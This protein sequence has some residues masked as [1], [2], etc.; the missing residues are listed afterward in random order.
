MTDG[1]H[2]DFETRSSVNLPKF[3]AYVYATDP[4]TEVLCMAYKWGC[5]PAQLWTPDKPFPEKVAKHIANGG[6]IIAH[7]AQFERLIFWYI[8]CPDFGV[9][10][11]E[12]EQFYCT[13]NLARSRGLP[14]KLELASAL[15]GGTGKDPRGDEL[16]RECCIPPYNDELLPELYEYC[17]T[18]V[19]AEAA[20][21][22]CLPALT[23][24]EQHDY[25]V[26]ERI[27]DRGV[28]VDV[29]F[30][31]AATEYKED[32][33][34]DLSVVLERVT[35]GEITKPTQSQRI[36]AWLAERCPRDCLRSTKTKSGWTSNRQALEMLLNEEDDVPAD[37]REVAQARLDGANVSVTKYQTMARIA[38]QDEEHRIRGAFILNAAITG[39]FSSRQA[40]LHNFPRSVPE[41]A[42]E[43]MD[44][45][46]E[47]Y[48]IETP[49]R[50]L[51]GLLRPTLI[52]AEGN[53]F[54]GG[55][56]SAIEA[57]LT[58]WA[59]RGWGGDVVVKRFADGVDVYIEQALDMGLTEEERQLG[60]VAILACGFGG[61]G[62]A[63]LS[64]GRN[65][66]LRLEFNEAQAYALAWRD[67]NRWAPALWAALERA[68][69]SAVRSP[70]ERFVAGDITYMMWGD[71]LCA[72]L[73]SG[74]VLYYYG[75]RLVEGK[76]G[77]PQLAYHHAR[78]IAQS[79]IESPPLVRT[80]GGKLC[81][82]VVQAMANDLLRHALR[83]A[84]DEGVPVV[85]H[86]HDE[87]L[88]EVP[89][90]TTA[91]TEARLERAMLESPPWAR[92]IPLKVKTWSGDRYGK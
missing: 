63:F 60:K 35:D 11:P 91:E 90:G 32:E 4:G 79:N 59:G 55:D 36:T 70:G 56:W 9:P 80:W 1:L 73:P 85:G 7:N 81:E 61:T 50:T 14:G 65:Y 75:A 78:Y 43:L 8:V 27:N 86:V 58:A 51:A 15:F 49:M 39:R 48:E 19:E 44:D 22:A 25:I 67:A 72:Q 92:D 16:I 42:V 20:F 29:R 52:P 17:L 57:V 45:V 26:S 74:R 53:V 46:L 5:A 40:Q 38:E 18:D 62:N 71:F 69:I 12:L 13:A 84:D 21:S 37:V 54:V 28:G 23:D 82:N 88:C 68:A 64:M 3:G 6:T 47:G 76:F 33:V 89:R 77:D 66:G 83:R 87:L 2:V 30:C 24:S 41:N 34:A 10:E 31:K